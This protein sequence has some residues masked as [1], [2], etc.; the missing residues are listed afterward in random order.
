MTPAATRTVIAGLSAAGAIAG[1]WMRGNALPARAGFGAAIV[2]MAAMQQGLT[3][4][5]RAFARLRHGRSEDGRTWSGHDGEDCATDRRSKSGDDRAN[6]V[7]QPPGPVRRCLRLLITVAALACLV[8]APARAA[9]PPCGAPPDLSDGW[10]VAAPADEGLNTDILCGIQAR[11]QGWPEAAMHAVLVVRHGKLVYE[12][13]FSGEDQQLGKSLGV[14]TFGP[15]TKHDLRSVSKSVTALVLGIEIG[16]G[17]IGGADTPVYAQFPEYADLRSPQKD[18]IVVRDLLTMSQ[19]L[20]WNEQLPYTDPRNS[21]IQMDD[22]ADPVRFALAAPAVTDPGTIYNY[23]GGSATIVAAL[24]R[25]ATGRSLDDLARTDLF[26]PLGITDWTWN[27]LNGGV[28]AGASGLRLRPRD[29]AKIGQVVLDHGRWKGQQI[30]PEAW[31]ADAIAPHIQGEG[32]FFYG[33]Q[34]WLGRSLIGG[35]EIGWAAGWGLGGQRMFVIPALDMV[36]IVHAG[37]YRSPLQ[38]VGPLAVLN[39]YALPAAR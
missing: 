2:A 8:F 10:T 6:G 11:F 1:P 24:L 37:L 38:S 7:K 39:R 35:R 12:Q 19:G 3:R 34:F 4:P 27:H 28:T 21:E 16:K 13:Y 18:R 33:Y 9:L 23:S 26:E 36:V 30:V 17:R 14:V 25:K 22:A 32:L 31:I 20:A 15:E 29:L 5:S